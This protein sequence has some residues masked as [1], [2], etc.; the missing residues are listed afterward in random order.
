MAARTPSIHV[1]LG[2]PLF[3]LSPGTMLENNKK[4]GKS[5]RFFGT[6]SSSILGLKIQSK[7]IEMG[8]VSKAAVKLGPKA[9]HCDEHPSYSAG[10]TS[11]DIFSSFPR[12]KCFVK[13]THSDN[14]EH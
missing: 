9:D 7:P 13:V 4:T 2:R 6:R 14:V 11:C 3:L 8:P 10:L 5:L 12:T 1:F